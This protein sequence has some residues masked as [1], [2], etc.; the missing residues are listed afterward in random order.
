LVYKE[1][2]MQ[3][4]Q[5]SL[6][7]RLG[8]GLLCLALL[9]GVG[10][11]SSMPTSAAPNNPRVP[12][13]TPNANCYKPQSVTSDIDGYAEGTASAKG[14]LYMN[15][16]EITYNFATFQRIE[17]SLK[18]DMGSAARNA[19]K[20]VSTIDGFVTHQ[21]APTDFTQFRSQYEFLTVQIEMV[22]NSLP[23]DAP[24][25]APWSALPG[26][27]GTVNYMTSPTQNPP[28]IAING[29]QAFLELGRGVTFTPG[30][31]GRTAYFSGKGGRKSYIVNCLVDVNALV[32]DIRSGNNSPVRFTVSV[33][34]WR[35]AAANAAQA[36]AEDYNN[37]VLF[38]EATAT[39]TP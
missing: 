2:I 23:A 30:V 21:A 16:K 28:P 20:W 24:I 6:Y 26:R 10:M 12:T 34:A 7:K 22:H 15:G 38:G 4:Y 1:A 29:T 37:R 5:I 11:F 35:D 39:P 9:M 27:M 17:F 3:S 13:N 8:M 25:W 31:S 14:G 33:A 19:G 36:A 18:I 32:N